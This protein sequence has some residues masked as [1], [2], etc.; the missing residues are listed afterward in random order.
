[1]STD[2][3]GTGPV[4][5]VGTIGASSRELA[6]DT[7]G[8]NAAPVAADEQQGTAQPDAAVV[9]ISAEAQAQHQSA[10]EQA[11]REAARAADAWAVTDAAS[12]VWVNDKPASDDG[13]VQ[14]ALD[15]LDEASRE[16][17]RAHVD[18]AITAQREHVASEGEAAQDVAADVE[19]AQRALDVAAT[20]ASIQLAYGSLSSPLAGDA[21]LRQPG[22]ELF[23]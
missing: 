2:V 11:L 9:T 17:L 5:G 22:L 23:A 10:D 13:V 1:M 21:V 15:A 20:N 8:R 18:A 7:R 4:A 3:I 12:R 16:N 19:T 14:E 6:D